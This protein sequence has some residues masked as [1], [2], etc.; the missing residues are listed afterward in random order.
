VKLIAESS[1]GRIVEFDAVRGAA[2]VDVCD[3]H[4][5]TGPVP[6]SRRELRNLPDL[7]ARGRRARLPPPR[8]CS[9]CST[10]STRHPGIRLACQTRLGPG[11]VRVHVEAIQDE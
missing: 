2:L 10:C 11:A 8:T 1:T 7:R 4:A 9:T 6:L 5:R 3:T